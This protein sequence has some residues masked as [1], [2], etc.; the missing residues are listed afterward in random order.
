[1]RE[2]AT[3]ALEDGAVFED[4]RDAVALQGFARRFKLPP[5]TMATVEVMRSCR[6]MRNSRTEDREVCFMV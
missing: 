2:A 4:L 3:R 6:S 5:S 1:V